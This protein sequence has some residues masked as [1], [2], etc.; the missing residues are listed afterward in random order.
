MDSSLGLQR[1]ERTARFLLEIVFGV[2]LV[3][4][5]F[6]SLISIAANKNVIAVF[7]AGGFVLAA[8]VALSLRR[9]RVTRKEVFVSV[10]LLTFVSF[11]FL[12]A[13]YESGFSFYALGGFGLAHGS[14]LAVMG[15]LATGVFAYLVGRHIPQKRFLTSFIIGGVLYAI[16]ILI[17]TLFGFEAF[18]SG[19]VTTFA[20]FL[21]V[22]ITFLLILSEFVNA[23]NSTTQLFYIVSLL[24]VAA[25]LVFSGSLQLLLVVSA[26][27]T[28]LLLASYTLQARSEMS[29]KF[30]QF[31][32]V[33]VLPLVVL[34]TIG[35]FSFFQTVQIFPPQEVRP[36][37]SA[38]THVALLSFA[39][40]PLRTLVGNGPLSF[41]R[42]WDLHMP[43][44]VARSV[45]W[46]DDFTH[47][48]SSIATAAIELG[49]LV[50]LVLVLLS[51]YV[52]T[53]FAHQVAQGKHM[54]LLPSILFLYLLFWLSTVAVDTP[55]LIIA[56]ALIG[57]LVGLIRMEDAPL[58]TCTNEEVST[59]D[60]VTLVFLSSGAIL[61][62][63][64]LVLSAMYASALHLY[65]SGVKTLR[66]QPGVYLQPIE[67]LE[68]STNI[69][70][71]PTVLQ[72]VSRMYRNSA[73]SEFEARG[74]D[75]T[76]EE[77]ESA[78]ELLG[79][80]VFFANEARRIS[81]N[82]YR[83]LLVFG[84]TQV[85]SGL[86][87]SDKETVNEGIQSYANAEAIAPH[88]PIA[89]ILHAQA[90][91]AAGR[92][93]EAYEIITV[94]LMKRPQHKISQNLEKDLRNILT[95]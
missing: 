42:V 38:T 32:I 30:F 18:D 68:K 85:F 8:A 14:I 13:M 89:Y 44:Q 62:V 72:T 37:W 76:P 71:L 33:A 70:S 25:A 1:V 59:T 84:E 11:F 94:A 29:P 75:L 34:G 66:E 4:L 2:L 9:I 45:F 54:Y 64:L 81:N 7:L 35:H 82:S 46:D 49:L 15:Y 92:F 51:V 58:H 53:L 22:G 79:H 17:L 3:M 48:V 90:L 61:A 20:T 41:S 16:S 87:N 67:Q 39:E 5:P 52:L 91:A 50:V 40:E 80:S 65:G 88:K 36:A 21:P 12:R 83:S 60:S 6:L 93:R 43:E 55:F 63:I 95:P 77:R 26:L 73:R 86:L 31:G 78:L 74:E 24:V 57:Y 23:K 27:S 69:L 19:S 56:L 47:G 10:L 28:L